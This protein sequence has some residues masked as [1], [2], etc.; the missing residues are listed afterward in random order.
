MYSNSKH[1]SRLDH[2]SFPVRLPAQAA[3][4]NNM[5]AEHCFRCPMDL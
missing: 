1:M 4:M 3:V 5:K 2:M